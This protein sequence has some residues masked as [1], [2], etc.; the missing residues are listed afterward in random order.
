MVLDSWLYVSNKRPG[1]QSVKQIRAYE[2][3]TYLFIHQ[4]THSVSIRSAPAVSDI[5]LSPRDIDKVEIV[6]VSRELSE[7]SGEAGMQIIWVTV[8][9]GGGES[10]TENRGDTALGGGRST[11]E[12]PGTLS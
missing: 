11:W 6:P 4:F 5:A 9:G 7:W 1:S 2:S 3:F 12:G 10:H 8:L